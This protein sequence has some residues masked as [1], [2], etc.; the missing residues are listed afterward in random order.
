MDSNG[1]STREQGS[2]QLR[3][4]LH[5]GF[6]ASATYTYSK[7]IDDSALGGRNQGTNVI[8]QNWLDL[9]AERGLSNFDQRHLLAFTTQYT[10]GQ[11]IGGGTLL[12]GWR[13]ALFK[14]WAVSTTI[15]AGTGLPLTPTV[16]SA[17]PGTGITGPLRPD[18]TGAPLYTAP[19]GFLLNPEAYALAPAGQWGNAGR[20]SITGPDQFS[21]NASLARTFR[22]KDR[23]SLDLRVDATNALNHVVFASWNTIVNSGQF[24]LPTPPANG[25]R[26]LQTTLRV[27]F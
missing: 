27:R 20:N 16:F 25:M 3:R 22:L 10:T 1:N 12:S 9:S 17:T 11:G 13:G 15:N 14:E 24:G 26:S 2:F 23:Y 8:A 18:Y 4:R 21:L 19:A 7:S 6:T 5:N